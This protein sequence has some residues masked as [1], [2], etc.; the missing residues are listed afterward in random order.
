MWLNDAGSAV[1]GG[2]AAAAA[3][4]M[5]AA[6]GRSVGQALRNIG[7][8]LTC[9]LIGLGRRLWNRLQVWVVA[10]YLRISVR[11]TPFL[12]SLMFRALVSL[13]SAP[14][15]NIVDL[16]ASPYEDHRRTPWSFTR[17]LADIC[18]HMNICNR[19][20]SV[21]ADVACFNSVQMMS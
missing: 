6:G 4:E 14:A 19:L 12:Q 7:H 17:L 5:A 8:A 16:G 10:I 1:V 11:A 2:I 3:V 13:C 9:G 20:L 21:P 15:G 18:F